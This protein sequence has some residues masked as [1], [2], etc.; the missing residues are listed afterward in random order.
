MSSFGFIQVIWF[1]S[2]AHLYRI[3][4]TFGGRATSISIVQSAVILK[5][6]QDKTLSAL[7]LLM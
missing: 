6:R 2:R 4:M 7:S 5:Q 1:F 3:G